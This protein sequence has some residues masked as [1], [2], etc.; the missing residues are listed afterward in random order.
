MDLNQD[1]VVQ[2]VQTVQTKQYRIIK[3][4]GIP[5]N[6]SHDVWYILNL[7]HPLYNQ[8]MNKIHSNRVNNV[9]LLNT[10][11]TYEQIYFLLEMYSRGDFM[12]TNGSSICFDT[13]VNLRQ[14]EIDLFR[15]ANYSESEDLE[16]HSP[17][18]I[19]ELLA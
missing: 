7:N 2:T 15:D 17:K 1:Q 18:N 3:A 19:Q 6:G 4:Y 16:Y 14:V 10:V 9:E 5:D 8:I 12:S 11:F 13:L